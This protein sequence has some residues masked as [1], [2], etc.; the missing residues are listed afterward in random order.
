MGSLK[1]VGVRAYLYL[2]HFPGKIWRQVISMPFL[3]GA[4]TP[5]ILLQVG[6]SPLEVARHFFFMDESRNFES[7]AVHIFKYV[8][9]HH[10]TWKLQASLNKWILQLQNTD[11]FGVLFFGW[12]APSSR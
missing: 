6:W 3:L 11:L 10:K 4:C 12:G 9:Y 8:K 2:I 5:Q 1:R 7:F